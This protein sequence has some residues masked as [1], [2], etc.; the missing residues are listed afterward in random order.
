MYVGNGGTFSNL[1]PDPSLYKSKNVPLY[2]A[3][4]AIEYPIQSQYKS[5]ANCI[6]DL[7]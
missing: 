3:N 2:D 4:I 1:Y 7:Q 6:T 5:I